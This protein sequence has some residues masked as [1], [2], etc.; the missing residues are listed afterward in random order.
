MAYKI[1]SKKTVESKQS[2]LCRRAV[3]PSS[4]QFPPRTPTFLSP[5]FLMITD[6]SLSLTTSSSVFSRTSTSTS[7]LVLL[8]KRKSSSAQRIYLVVT[9]ETARFLPANQQPCRQHGVGTAVVTRGT[10]LNSQWP[11]CVPPW[12]NLESVGFYSSDRVTTTGSKESASEKHGR[13]N[14]F[15]DQRL[16]RRLESPSLIRWPL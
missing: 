8:L 3:S 1:C 15:L 14:N 7:I 4:P 16:R 12:V 9:C 5:S 11:D 10:F 13:D 6:R 2:T